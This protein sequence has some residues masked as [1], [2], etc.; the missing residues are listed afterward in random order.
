MRKALVAGGAGFVGS[1][2]VELL[3]EN[4]YEVTVI[5]NL[6]TGQTSNIEMLK[7]RGVKWINAGI[8]DSPHLVEAYDEIYNLASP[9]SPIDFEIMPQ[10][11]LETAALGHRNL[12][13]HAR[14]TGGR[15]LFTSSSEAYGDPAIHPQV[16]TYFGNVNPVGP[17]S[18]YDE[19]KRFGEALSTTYFRVH[20]TPVRIARIFNT[21]GPRMRPNDGRILPNFFSQ[22]HKGEDLTVHGAGSQTRSFCFVTDLAAGLFALMQKGDEKP[23]NLGNPREMTVLEVAERV[24]ALTG[25]RSRIRY[26]ESREED[27]KKRQPDITRAK[28]MLGWEP[29]VSFEVG[30]KKTSDFFASVL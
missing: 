21:Y 14:R 25:G 7:S 13:E 28:T 17:R 16:E 19:G 24:I 5:D 12:L 6:V 22:A 30:L 27:P 4:G 10:F 3:L 18:C 23:T 2:L 1:H 15:V 11:I 20:K 8:H 26:I 9:A 29:N